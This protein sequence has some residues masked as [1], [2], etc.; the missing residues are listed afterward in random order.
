MQLNQKNESSYFPKPNESTECPKKLKKT[1]KSEEKNQCQKIKFEK[2]PKKINSQE[3]QNNTNQIKSND[4]SDTLIN[5]KNYYQQSNNIIQPQLAQAC[6]ITERP[7]SFNQNN[8][9]N[10]YQNYN[11]QQTQPN[12][13]NDMRRNYVPQ[14]FLGQNYMID[15]ISQQQYVFLT[16]PTNSQPLFFPN[17]T[18]ND[19]FICN[20]PQRPDLYLTNYGRNFNKNNRDISKMDK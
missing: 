18:A 17:Y 6:Q 11:N 20:Q 16:Y 5:C 2:E 4:S 9:Q 8:I 12:F 7:Y 3:L 1:N 13:S 15:P 19:R 10:F 14:I